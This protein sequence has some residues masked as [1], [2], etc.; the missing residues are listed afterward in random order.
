MGLKQ[1]RGLFNPVVKEKNTS[2][3]GGKIG[4]V[5]P[6]LARRFGQKDRV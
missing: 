4:R 6:M 2:I 1:G 3:P 5:V